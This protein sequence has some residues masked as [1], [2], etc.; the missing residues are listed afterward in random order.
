MS[1][2][3]SDTTGGMANEAHDTA[4]YVDQQGRTV[5]P[6][7]QAPQG[8]PGAAAPQTAGARIDQIGAYVREQPVSTALLAL[9]VGYIIGRL[10]IL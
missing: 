7:P 10:R 5:P 9:G 1:D 4:A 3:L 8:A 6:P 2:T